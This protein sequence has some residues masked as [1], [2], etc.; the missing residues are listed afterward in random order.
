[1]RLR[2]AQVRSHEQGERGQSNQAHARSLRFA[3]M[4]SFPRWVRFVK[5]IKR[6][7]SPDGAQRH[8]GTMVRVARSSPHFASAQCGLQGV[9]VSKE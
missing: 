5:T 9:A 2:A 7:R 4:G 1:L 6:S 3:A 8:P